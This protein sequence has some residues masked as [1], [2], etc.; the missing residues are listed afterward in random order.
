M[1]LYLLLIETII[2][3]NY[4]KQVNKLSLFL[5]GRDYRVFID[6][7]GSL[8]GITVAGSTSDPGPYAYQF[9][10]PTAV[11]FDP[12]GYLY[13]MDSGNSRIQRW[14]P[15]SS[16]GVTVAASAMSTPYSMKIDPRGNLV[17]MDTF[18]Y[19]VISFA[20]TCRKLY[21]FFL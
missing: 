18:N 13:V 8:T 21:T 4:G 17:V 15:R 2:E 10:S 14:Y 5:V 19:R 16:Y 6:Y 7:L 9:S 12:Y 3:F 20:M 1:D 11:A